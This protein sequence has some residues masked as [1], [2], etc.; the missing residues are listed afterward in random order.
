[1]GQPFPNRKV[2]GILRNALLRVS[3]NIDLD[4][5]AG[6]CIHWSIDHSELQSYRY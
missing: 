2:N 1:L 6:T 4:L 3:R 5:Q